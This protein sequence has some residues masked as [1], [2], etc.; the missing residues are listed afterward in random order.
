MQRNFE[1]HNQDN[2][3]MTDGEMKADVTSIMGLNLA[4]SMRA[5]LKRVAKLF[6]SEIMNKLQE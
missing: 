3:D 6:A 1:N 5:S 2:E 4:S